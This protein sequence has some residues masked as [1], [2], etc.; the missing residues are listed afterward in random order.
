MIGNFGPIVPYYL[1]QIYYKQKKF[2]EVVK[3]APC[4]DGECIGKKGARNC[5]DNR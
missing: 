4:P 1:T 2:D 5:Q 3:Y